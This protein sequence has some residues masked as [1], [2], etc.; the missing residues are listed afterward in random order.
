MVHIFKGVRKLGDRSVSRATALLLGFV[1]LRDPI[2]FVSL[3]LI[4]VPHGQ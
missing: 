3:Y 2:A 4:G 1:V